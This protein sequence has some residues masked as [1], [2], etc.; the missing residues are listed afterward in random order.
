MPDCKLV[1]SEV[2]APAQRIRADRARLSL[3]AHRRA[4]W[5]ARVQR[6]GRLVHI[7]AV[8]LRDINELAGEHRSRRATTNR[9]SIGR[10]Q[11][12]VAR[13][14]HGSFVQARLLLGNQLTSLLDH[15]AGLDLAPNAARECRGA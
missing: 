8:N 6:N 3:N 4:A 9:R 13:A 15:L 11:R 12:V 5:G 7:P 1:V 10:R 2:C 14:A